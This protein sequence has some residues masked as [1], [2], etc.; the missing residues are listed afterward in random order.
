M[1]K[2]EKQKLYEEFER[3]IKSVENLSNF[4][5]S[6]M[7]TIDAENAAD[8]FCTFTDFASAYLLI[9]VD[10]MLERQLKIDELRNE[11]IDHE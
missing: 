5:C 2:Q 3:L 9:G 8:L 7:N 6:H 4:L 1:T 10:N 11:E